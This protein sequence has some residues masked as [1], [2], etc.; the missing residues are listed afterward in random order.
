MENIKNSIYGASDALVLP[1]LMLIGTPFFL[2]Y[3]GVEGYATWVLINSVIASLSFFNFG[4]ADVIVKFVSSS[5]GGK[6]RCD[7]NKDEAVKVFSTVFTF[8]TL[9]L[10]MIYGLF[11]I[12]ASFIDQLAISKNLLRFVD[13]LYIAIPV[14]FFKQSEQLLYAFLRGK[15]QF[16]QVLVMSGISKVLFFVIQIVVSIFT[17]S[18]IDVFYG[19]LIISMLLF[20]LQVY[21]MKF[22]Q[23]ENISFSRVSVN[24]AKSLLNFGGWNWASSLASMLKSDS[25]KWLV[26][27]L[28]GLKV[29]GIYSIGVM[30][31]NQLH[32]I[33]ASSMA[34]IFPNISKNNLSKEYLSKKYWKLLFTVGILGLTISFALTSLGVLFELWLGEEFYQDSQYYISTFLLIFPIFTLTIVPYFYL[35]GLGLVKHK[36]F[37]D[38][39]SF[40]AKVVTLWLVINVFNIEE[41]V[42]FFLIFIIVEYVAYSIVISRNLPI[43]FLHLMYVL[44][45]QLVIVFFRF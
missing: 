14:F 26:S 15:E 11:I 7:S 8:Q 37:V 39:A 17:Q 43:K 32:R 20:L 28:L 40:V 4:G 19:A 1:I 41:W 23:K 33:M 22:I 5:R 6:N 36:F 9:I 38:M 35:L 24:T 34:W 44:L 25:D 42:L 10:L 27:W 13:I 16:A 21:Y 3:L 30:V 2:H 29:F 45:F 12:A 18:V 31:F